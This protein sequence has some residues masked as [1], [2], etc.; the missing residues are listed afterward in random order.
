MKS[1]VEK[2][3]DTRVKLTVEVPFDELSAEIDRS[4]KAIAKQVNIPG[5]RK[6]KA[7]RQLIDARFG[8]G[9]VLEQ[10]VNDMLPTKYNEAIEEAEIASRVLG[11]PSVEIT[12]LEDGD[13]VEFTAEVDV[14]PEFE[15]PDFSALEVEVDVLADNDEAVAAEL[16]EMRRRFST[17]TAVERAV[18]E[19]DFVSVN[20]EAQVNDEANEDFTTSEPLEFEVGSDPFGYKGMSEQL[21]GKSA[22]DKFSFDFEADGSDAHDEGAKVAFDVEVVEVKEVELPELDDDF[23]EMVSSFDTVEELRE[24]VAKQV[25]ERAK[26][27]QAAQI[28]DL[29]LKEA[30]D[31]VSFELPEAMVAEQV[32][33]QAQQLLSQLGGDEKLFAQLLSA[34]GKTREEFDAENREKCEKAVRVQL[35]LDALAAEVSPEVSPAEVSDHM[36]FTAQ[37]YGMDPNQFMQQVMQSGQLGTL[38]ADV[39]RGKALAAAICDVK[40]MDKNGDS[41]DASEYFGEEEESETDESAS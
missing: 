16:D 29:V 9:L 35:F 38:Y 5:F 4:Y 11:Q 41:V 6:G 7:P 31:A 13:L 18:A 12:K 39:R 37:A 15:L 24:D 26:A 8:R 20:V 14:R 25:T 32:N 33:N 3:S 1:S 30:V 23:A 2:L 10:V 21:I 27:A 36:M 34:Q 22:G 17:Q 28:R 19:G 40:V